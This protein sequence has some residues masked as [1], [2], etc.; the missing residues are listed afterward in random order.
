[1][2]P[3]LGLLAQPTTTLPMYQPQRLPQLQHLPLRGLHYHVR[4]WGTP[5]AHTAPVVLLH[6]WM[7][8]GAS[9]QWVVDALPADFFKQRYLIAPDWRGFGHTQPNGPCDSFH[10]VDYLADLDALLQALLPADTAIDLVGHS[11]GAN[12]AMLYAAARPARVRH[13]V[14]LEGFG[15][16]ATEPAQAPQRLGQ[17]LDQLNAYRSG[18]LRLRPY[19]S[20]EAVAAQ[21]QKTNP[22]LPRDH[23]LWLAGEWAAPHTQADGQVQWQ[24]LGSAAHK[25]ANP[26]LFRLEE[27]L[28][29]YRAITAP[30]LLLEADDD[31]L[32]QMHGT[33]YTRA[34]FAP[35]IAH[36]AHLRTVRIPHAGHMLQ[37]DQP[38]LVAQH[39]SDFLQSR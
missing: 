31:T 4:T 24:L 38:A 26:Y 18:Q 5:S 6:G 22:R 37:H 33:R 25:V 8:V 16:P 14:N 39:I 21:L 36:V 35:R 19:D 9:W 30:V 17:W 2:P 29:Y 15:L 10:F 32:A 7:D 23:A 13:L 27:Y 20:R 34:D 3:L 12:V 11:M 1:M 28:A